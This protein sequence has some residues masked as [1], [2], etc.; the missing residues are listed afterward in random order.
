VLLVALA[1]AGS[2][3]AAR[4]QEGGPPAAAADEMPRPAES[5]A[6]V[7][8]VAPP[9]VTVTPVVESVEFQNRTYFKDETLRSFLT[10]PVPGELDEVLLKG[11]AERIAAR[12]RDRGFLA[13]RVDLKLVPTATP[14][15]VKAIFIIDAGERAELKRVKVVGNVEV[16]EAALKEGFF[17]RPP[18]F[19]GAVTR[20]GFFHKPYLDQD[21]QRLVANYYRRGY[22]EAR[23]LDTR[24]EA[25]PSLDGLSVTLR[26]VE[27][28]QY[29][30]GALVFTG[31]MPEGVSVEEM[32]SR[33][34]VKDG[35]VCDLVTIQQQADVL[36]EPLRAAGHPFARIEQS[37]Q[38]VPPPSKNPEHRAV[39]LTLRFIRGPRPTV[40]SV[41][42]SGNTGTQE[43]VIRRDVEVKEGQPYDHAA[44]KATERALMGTGFFSAVQARAVPTEDANVVDVEVAVTEQQTWLASIAPAVDGTRGGEGLIGVG[45][46]ADR[47]FLGTGLFISTFARISAVRQN[48]DF[49]LTEP[50]LLDTRTSLTGELHRREI[51]YRGFKT[52]SDLGG[53][54]RTSVPVGAGFFV[55]GGIGVEYGGVVLLDENRDADVIAEEGRNGPPLALDDAGNGLLP[56]KVFR[57]PVSLSVAFDKRDSVL[58]PR[59]GVYVNLSSSYAGAFTLSGLG[60]LDTGAQLKL[61]WTPLWGI[62]LK[63]NTDVGFVFNPHG[64]EVPVTDRYFLG[65]LGSVRGYPVLSLSPKRT[66]PLTE[67]LPKDLFLAC[68]FDEPSGDIPPVRG[69]SLDV[70]GTVR[71]V[72]NLEVEFPIW[73]DTPFRGFLFLDAGNAF[74]GEELGTLLNGGSIDDERGATLPFGLFFST[75]FGILIETPVLPFRLEWSVPLTRRE[76]DQPINFFLGI[77]SAF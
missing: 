38:V 71:A 64:G 30:L 15:G 75:G 45:V 37:V 7:A 43:R 48:F 65:G 40:R 29:E 16:D 31:E 34:T 26:V 25:D 55:G 9:D 2:V 11:D 32:R 61:F 36:L 52:R 12:F 49:S 44:M 4:A 62:T 18:E 50:R 23:V 59:N 28:P 72:Q 42:I 21:A 1:W 35:D 47:N 24:V 20:A 66:L 74:D 14:R 39:A 27:G 51:T 77:G 57:N 8:N 68:G 60:F 56:S 54:V 67:N 69:C 10:H 33:I 46:L 70:G 22:L 13:A 73:P 17:S 19:L 76:F 3:D 53:G 41:R 5:D 63:S 6:P 58:L